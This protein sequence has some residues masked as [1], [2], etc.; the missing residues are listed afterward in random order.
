M[1]KWWVPRVAFE[2]VHQMLL[3]YGHAGYGDDYPVGQRLRDVLSRQLTEGTEQIMKR[4]IARELLGREL[5]P[6]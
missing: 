2:T 6:A 5:A 1:A 3:L 4:I